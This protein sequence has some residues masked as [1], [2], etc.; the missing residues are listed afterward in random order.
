[1][2]VVLEEV[3]TPT[4]QKRVLTVVGTR[5]CF[6]RVNLGQSAWQGATVDKHF[7]GRQRHRDRISA[8]IC[9]VLYL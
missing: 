9:Y 2:S 4:Y 3:H 5:P 7:L 6:L 8:H 1:M